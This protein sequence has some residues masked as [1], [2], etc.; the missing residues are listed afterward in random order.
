MESLAIIELT[1]PVYAWAGPTRPQPLN[2]DDRSVMLLGNFDQLYVPGLAGA[3]DG[4]SSPHA[5][6][7]FYGLMEPES[8]NR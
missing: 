2:Q 7:V 6:V 3:A 5:Y 8:V 1:K 4:T